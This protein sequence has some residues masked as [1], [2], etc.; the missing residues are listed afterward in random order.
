MQ[1]VHIHNAVTIELVIVFR[2]VFTFKSGAGV[3]FG[4]RPPWWAPVKRNH[5]ISSASTF[6]DHLMV[7]SAASV[8]TFDRTSR[9][10]QCTWQE[11]IGGSL[12]VPLPLS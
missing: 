5:V 8:T 7:S 6:A 2:Q 3:A 9:R 12:I 4:S 11:V 1:N 10:A